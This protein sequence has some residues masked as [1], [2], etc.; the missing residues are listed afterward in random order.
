MMSESEFFAGITGRSDDLSRVVQAL[1]GAGVPFCL[2]GGLAVN[3]Y[4]DPVVTL[5]ADFAITA[6]TGVA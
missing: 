1:S 5:D 3:Q 2:I 4:V 6:A